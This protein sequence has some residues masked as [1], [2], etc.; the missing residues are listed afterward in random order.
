LLKRPYPFKK[1]TGAA[2]VR[3]PVNPFKYWKLCVLFSIHRVLSTGF[4]GAGPEEGNYPVWVLEHHCN[5]DLERG[6][7]DK[8]EKCEFFQKQGFC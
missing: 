2:R 3:E 8:S 4:I 6:K 7:F 5:N 1:Q